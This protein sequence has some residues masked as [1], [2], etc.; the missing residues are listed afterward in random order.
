MESLNIKVWHCC[1]EEEH[2]DDSQHATAG[3]STE[4]LK[5]A[6]WHNLLI[7]QNELCKVCVCVSY[8]HVAASCIRDDVAYVVIHRWWQIR[9][10]LSL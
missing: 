3:T 4:L 10:L 1:L 7:E 2:A 5:S 8:K 9:P 6:G